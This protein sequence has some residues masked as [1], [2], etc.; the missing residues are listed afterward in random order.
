[1]L[2]K[3]GRYLNSYLLLL[4]FLL[5]VELSLNTFPLLCGQPQ[6]LHFVCAN[7]DDDDDEQRTLIG[8]AIGIALSPIFGPILSV[9]VP[10]VS[11]L[12]AVLAVLA[13]YAM[14]GPLKLKPRDFIFTAKA[15]VLKLT[16]G[17]CARRRILTDGMPTCDGFF[18]SSC[19]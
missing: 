8:I 9:F 18:C 7:C 12:A 10:F 6:R 19:L 2:R 4:L 11:L 1:M 3:V 13:A 16:L 5:V 14:L 17:Y 15:A